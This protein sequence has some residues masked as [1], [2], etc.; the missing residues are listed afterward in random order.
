MM[1]SWC[2]L[3]KKKKCDASN[4]FF[5]ME[6]QSGF[7]VPPPSMASAVTH[8]QPPIEQYGTAWF[9]CSVSKHKSAL[10]LHQGFTLGQILLARWIKRCFGKNNSESE[11]GLFGRHTPEVGGGVWGH[12]MAIESK[13]WPLTSSCTQTVTGKRTGASAVTN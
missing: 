3:S 6:A 11:A 5:Y 7:S 10:Y 1:L 9:S 12:R 4:S 13:E 8:F 2:C